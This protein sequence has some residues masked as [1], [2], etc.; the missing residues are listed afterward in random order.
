[1]FEM[2]VRVRHELEAKAIL[3][4]DVPFLEVDK[5]IPKLSEWGGFMFPGDVALSNLSGQFVV[6]H[7][8]GEAYFEVMVGDDE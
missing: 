2:Q 6:D 1:V 8:T 4:G 5:V 7:D 3:L